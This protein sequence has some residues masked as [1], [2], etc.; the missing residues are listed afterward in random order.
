MRKRR[1]PRLFVGITEVGDFTLRLSDGLR[2]L[3]CQVTNVV[4]ATDKPVLR[5]EDSH[6]RYIDASGRYRRYFRLMREFARAAATH[7]TFIFSFAS[8]FSGGLLQSRKRI[9][10]ALAFRDLAILRALGKKIV[11]VAQGSDLRSLTMLVRDMHRAGLGELAKYVEADIDPTYGGS[12]DYKRTKAQRIERHADFIFARPNSAQL[13]TRDYSLVWL[14]V[15]LDRLKYS[16]PNNE[17]PYVV[18]AP[19]SRVVKGTKYILEAC[20]RL[21]QEGIRHK[22]I[23]CEGMDNRR[24]REVL[25]QADIVVDQVILPGYG[26]FALEAMGSGCAVVG[27]AYPEYNGNPADLPILTATPDTIYEKLRLAIFDRELRI[28]LAQ[29]GRA[30]VEEHHDHVQVAKSFLREI[31]ERV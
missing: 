22:L 1:S 3:G 27:S 6:D 13:L 23:L 31:G 10:R 19:T 7:D 29:R 30:Y 5:R 26:L 14:P 15:R 21:K 17:I 24:V 28:G 12:D 2:A 16:V 4:M 9:F 8:S 25:T 11:I 18:H 20:E